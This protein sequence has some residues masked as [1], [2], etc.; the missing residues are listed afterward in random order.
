VFGNLL[1][2][3]IMASIFFN[4]NK[5]AQQTSEV[6]N[7]TNEDG[8]E[9]TAVVPDINKI[10]TVAVFQFE[11]LT[12]DKELDWWGVAFSDLLMNDLEQRP[13]FYVYSAYP[14]NSYYD[15]LGLPL[16]T[17]PNVGM[18]R[19]IAQKSRNDYFSNISFDK[20]DQ[21]FVLKGKL[22]SS[23]DGKPLIDLNAKNEDPYLAID[24]IKDQITTNIPNAFI[25]V[26]N[27]VNLPASTLISGNQK[28]LKHQ[29]Q[30][31]IA[32]YMNPSKLD[33][34]IELSKQAVKTDPTCSVCHYSLGNV[35]YNNGQ[36]DESINYLK[37]AIKYSASLPERMQ[38]ASK[39]AF[40]SVTNK[41]D[42]QMKLLEVQRRMFPYEFSPY[43]SL[44]SMY[45]ITY[46]IDSAKILIQ[47]AIDNG[48]VERGL[49]VLHNL[50]LENEEYSAAE[51]TL[52][53]FFSE[54][55]DRKQ[56]KAKYANIYER[57]GKLQ[58]AREILLKEEALDPLNTSIQTRLAY[59][60]FK[61]M[62]FTKVDERVNN[63][64]MQSTSNSDSLNFLWMKGY[65]FKRQGQISNAF[66]SFA[67][68]EKY[69]TK[70]MTYRRAI[71]NT[72]NNKVDMYLSI[73]Q[74]EKINDLMTERLKYS[75]ED[76]AIFNCNI[77]V[78]A[79]HGGYQ[80]FNMTTEEFENCRKVYEAYGEGYGEYIDVLL[81]YA[82]EDYQSCLIA[83]D[84][85]NGRMEKII[86]D[87]YLLANIFAKAG[88]RD[89]AKEILQKAIDQKIDSPLYYYEMAIL[90]EKT[91]PQEAKK[92]LDIALQFWTN[93]DDNFIP[94]QRARD[95]AN[96]LSI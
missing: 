4:G 75:P 43:Q 58:E 78:D 29:T 32:F 42:A 56:D 26:E 53:S 8:E 50:Q 24:E 59:L 47:E 68:Y 41:M 31:Q 57:Q 67:N 94:A 86:G 74:S 77:N 91:E 45:R 44:L 65:F 83:L 21:Q 28:A 61:S 66:K 33:E 1:V 48:N 30:S 9:V 34:V 63:G 40:Y 25:D 14:L 88:K 36:R 81:A 70:R 80:M 19:K 17:I 55:P 22:Y 6:L 89:K 27:Q 79:I 90:L 38:F 54:F 76:E 69:G 7:L 12:G 52:D 37:N 82:K 84:E 62:D 95:L 5:T 60:D 20:V 3:G 11:N 93:A 39:S 72:F 18:Q 35:L 16:F 15:Q 73:G 23:R 71:G 2:A 13:E 85:D 92:Y 51:K 49:L 96:R 87:K 46:G 64:L 10:K